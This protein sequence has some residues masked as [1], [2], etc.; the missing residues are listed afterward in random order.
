MQPLLFMVAFTLGIMLGARA[1]IALNAK[2]KSNLNTVADVLDRENRLKDYQIS[3]SI[4][5]AY[6]YDNGKLIGATLHGK[7]GIDSLIAIDNQ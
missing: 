5:S 1:A 4:D 6:L 7:D 3:L 2:N